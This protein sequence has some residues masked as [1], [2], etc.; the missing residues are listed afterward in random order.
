MFKHEMVNEDLQKEAA[1]LIDNYTIINFLF[2]G[3]KSSGFQLPCFQSY[4]NKEDSKIEIT[5][6]DTCE[7]FL[8]LFNENRMKGA[9]KEIELR[10]RKSLLNCLNETTKNKAMVIFVFYIGD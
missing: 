9:K 2:P 4:Q 5:E 7:V 6:G 10:S 3:L 8:K 1:N